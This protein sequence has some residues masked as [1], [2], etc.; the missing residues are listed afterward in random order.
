MSTR[1]VIADDHALIRQGLRHALSADEAVEIVGEAGSAA[2]AAVVIDRERPDVVLI[3]VMLG[4]GN[5][6]DV[7]RTL[8]DRYPTLGIVIL[9]MHG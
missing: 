9:T 2:E 8:R 3:D 6:L 7:A 5:G 1:L 4:D